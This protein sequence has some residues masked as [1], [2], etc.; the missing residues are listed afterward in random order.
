M[1][2]KKRNLDY[3]SYLTPKHLPT[4]I[5]I[6]F[7]W[8]VSY[9]PLRLQRWLG[10]SIGWVSY[11]LMKKRR[12]IT[13]VNIQLCFPELSPYEQNAL[14]KSTFLSNGI[15][16]FES[17]TGWFRDPEALRSLTQVHGYEHIEAAKSKG[18]G[19]ILLGGHYSTLDLG[20][21]LVSLFIDADV[22]QRDHNNPLFNAVMTR[23][24]LKHYEKALDRKDV[25]GML[26]CLKENRIVWY[27]TDQDYGR[28]N[29]L[30]VPFFG[31][32]AATISTT[33]RIAKS[34]GAA[35]VPF[36]HFRREGQLGYDIYFHPPLTQFPTD[37]LLA[38]TTR[39]NRLLEREIRKHPDQYLWMHRRFKTTVEPE[40]PSPYNV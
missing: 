23:S 12:H 13:S 8:C 14:I 7:L 30:F 29:S 9:L 3:S 21:A 4:W 19:V 28:K 11:Y 35:V 33:A 16:I 18:A 15:G 38:D 26:R 24:R 10:V 32:P 36:S 34:S 2:K 25:R 1:N 40:S 6:V 39:L 5:A 27:A 20:G 22:M 37:D 17:V 31:V